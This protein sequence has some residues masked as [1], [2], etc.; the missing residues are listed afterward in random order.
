[1]LRASRGEAWDPSDS[2]WTAPAPLCTRITGRYCPGRGGGAA[3][4]GGHRCH[5]GAKLL[6]AVFLHHHLP[7]ARAAGVAGNAVQGRLLTPCR[8]TLQAGEGEAHGGALASG[9]WCSQG[10]I[11]SPATCR[12]QS[13]VDLAAP[14]SDSRSWLRRPP[15]GDANHDSLHDQVR[16][17]KGARRAARPCA[18]ARPSPALAPSL[19]PG[20]GRAACR[21]AEACFLSR[22]GT[23]ALQISMNAP[24]MVELDEKMTDP[25][26]A[27]ARRRPSRPWRAAAL[28]VWARQTRVGRA[29]ARAES[30]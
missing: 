12:T 26:E 17:R 9:L 23:R 19:S 5:G 15:P 6:L 27:R 13:P 14:N 24:V 29:L 10:L 28:S 2:K 16:T 18:M 7:P 1:M 22:A 11:C 4:R 20:P 3:A 30:A 21:D 25:L 8:S